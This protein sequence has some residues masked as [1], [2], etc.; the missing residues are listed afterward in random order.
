L[1][2]SSNFKVVE[3]NLGKGL[4]ATKKIAKD[5]VILKMS[6]KILRNSHNILSAPLESHLIQIGYNMY[7]D[8]VAPGRFTNHSCDPN[9]ILC[10]QLLIAIKDMAKD[11]EITFDYSTTMDENNYTLE[12]LCGS[13]LC[14]GTVKDFITLPKETRQKYIDLGGVQHFILARC[15]SSI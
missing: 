11:E 3:T 9:S 10:G 8:P 5:T 4:M 1:T 14:R 15:F 7:Y 6:G 12:C 2:N 13:N